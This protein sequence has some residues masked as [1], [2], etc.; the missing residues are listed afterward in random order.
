[1]LFLPCVYL[2]EENVNEFENVKKELSKSIGR[3]IF[4][5][6]LK[7]HHLHGQRKNKTTTTTTDKTKQNK[8]NKRETKEEEP[9]LTFADHPF[10][11]QGLLAMDMAKSKSNGHHLWQ[12]S[13]YLLFFYTTKF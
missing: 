4:S 13:Y 3:L 2:E 10:Q 1:M 7:R 8:Q 5:R 6:P 12:T 11:P 9:G